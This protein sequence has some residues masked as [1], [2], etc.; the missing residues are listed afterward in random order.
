MN[1]GYEA[2]LT[3]Y[4]TISVFF[5]LLLVLFFIKPTI[6]ASVSLPIVFLN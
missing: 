3:F 5:A 6:V 2:K 4:K 1:N